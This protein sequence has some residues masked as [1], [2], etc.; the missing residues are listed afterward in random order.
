MDVKFSIKDSNRIDPMA[1]LD[2][3]SKIT[4]NYEFFRMS[5][6]FRFLTEDLEDIR[7]IFGNV[8]DRKI[9]LVQDLPN[10]ESQYQIHKI[11]QMLVSYVA[12]VLHANGIELVDAFFSQDNIDYSK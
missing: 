11:S 4:N 12:E 10:Q 3:F 9:C 5:D 1:I 6:S 8:S 2:K 7:Q